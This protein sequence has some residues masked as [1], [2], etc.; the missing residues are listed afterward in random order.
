MKRGDSKYSYISNLDLVI[1][2]RQS[3]RRGFRQLRRD[4]SD[5]PIG[6]I[7]LT[8]AAS[9]LSSTSRKELQTIFQFLKPLLISPLLKERQVLNA[10]GERNKGGAVAGVGRFKKRFRPPVQIGEEVG[11]LERN[12]SLKFY[13]L[14]SSYIENISY[15]VTVRKAG[16]SC[17][18][19]MQHLERRDEHRSR[20][21]G[22]TRARFTDAWMPARAAAFGTIRRLRR[23]RE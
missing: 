3:R 10:M 12:A 4:G 19:D 22:R 16:C 23:E 15:S 6:K 5:L 20:T 14:S 9:S 18:E 21:P 7:A 8:R 17:R 11:D 13:R 1:Q 2:A